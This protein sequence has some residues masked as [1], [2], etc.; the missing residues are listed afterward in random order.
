MASSRERLAS[1]LG[2][3]LLSA[4]LCY[5]SRQRMAFSLDY[6]PVWRRVVCADLSVLSCCG[7]SAHHGHGIFRGTGVT[8]Q[9]GTGLSRA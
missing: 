8:S 5:W 1:R 9:Y 6:G 4:G 2:F 7:G 3:L